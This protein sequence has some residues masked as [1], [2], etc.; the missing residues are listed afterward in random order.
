MIKTRKVSPDESGRELAARCQ[1]FMAAGANAV[2]SEA[3]KC[4]R[5]E[6]ASFPPERQTTEFDYLTLLSEG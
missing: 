3:Q 4:A 6:A 5:V 1:Y 2:I